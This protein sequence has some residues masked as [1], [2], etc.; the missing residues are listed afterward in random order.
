MNK[1]ITLEARVLLILL[2]GRVF[3]LLYAAV[4]A[5]TFYRGLDSN[6]NI[7]LYGLVFLVSAIQWNYVK[8]SV[9]R[10]IYPVFHYGTDILLLTLVLAKEYNASAFSLYLIFVC[11]TG[12]AGRPISAI[13]VG[14]LSGISYGLLISGILSLENSRFGDL[15]SFNILIS[16]GT[17]VLASIISSLASNRISELQKSVSKTEE[18]LQRLSGEQTQ[19]MNSLTEG[20]ITLDLASAITGINDAAKAILGLKDLDV[21]KLVGKD[22]KTSLTSLGIQGVTSEF[23]PDI[24]FGTDLKL[25]SSGDRVLRCT[26]R[27]LVDGDGQNTGQVLFLSDVSELKNTKDILSFHEEMARAL[28]SKFTD[29]SLI[30]VEGSLVGNSKGIKKVLDLVAK[31]A[32]SEAPVLVLGESG[33]GKELVASLVHDL[34]K[35]NDGPFITV[36]CGAIPESLIESELFGHK[37]GAFTGADRE[38]KGLFREAHGGTLFLDEIGEL[39]LLLQVKILRAIQYKVIR[40]VGASKEEEVD[41]R[42]ISATNRDLKDDVKQGKFREDLYYR[43]KVVEAFIPPLRERREDIMPLI[44]H[45]LGLQGFVDME[46]RISPEALNKMLNY[47][48]PG[49]V[50]ELENMIQRAMVLGG[51]VILPEHLPDEVLNYIENERNND[52]EI[53]PNG[54]SKQRFPVDLEDM[55]ESLEKKFL[56]EALNQTEG[57]KKE[58]SKLLNLNF[59]SFRYRLK[60]Y[61]LGGDDEDV[62]N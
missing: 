23:G 50:R 17:L 21:K 39:P 40:P 14:A 54:P 41:V 28:G 36:N 32:P 8:K 12:L 37:K 15:N 7:A 52:Y 34:S 56:V 10:D 1:S 6:A 27:S 48:Y 62:V 61:D 22:I 44:S 26:G 51:G 53:E 58:A 25:G 20:V 35:R 55:L 49:N 29:E 11:A 18:S 19:L 30:P 60:K 9:I 31:V 59:R 5:K 4:G 45:F 24:D 33:T 46:V 16:Y 43:L 57:K 47:N 13:V 3:G 2:F 38:T 42:I